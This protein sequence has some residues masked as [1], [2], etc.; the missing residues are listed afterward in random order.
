MG[1]TVKRKRRKRKS[2]APRCDVLRCTRRPVRAGL[3]ATHLRQKADAA[4]SRHIRERDGRCRICNRGP[5]AQCCHIV[6]RNYRQ[7]R[8][9]E[10]NAVAGCAKCHVKFT[11]RPLEWIDW[12]DA[13]FG[14][15][16]Y[17]RLRREALDGTADWRDLAAE[18]IGDGT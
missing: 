12:I 8:W 14:D 7:V 9:N 1:G 10:A 3:C 5:A 11:H 6:S 13:T 4:F 17:E 16:T 18:W 2:T 15:G